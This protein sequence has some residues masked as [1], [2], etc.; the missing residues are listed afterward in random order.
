MSSARQEMVQSV[1]N[2]AGESARKDED[3]VA[4]RFQESWQ[5]LSSA[6]S[7]RDNMLP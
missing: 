5:S 1:G 7:D 3:L 4:I 2:T 6:S